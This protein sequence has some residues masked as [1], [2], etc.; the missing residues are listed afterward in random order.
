MSAQT[1]ARAWS[2][3]RS[4]GMVL[5]FTDHDRRLQFGG[6]TFRPD[7]G[8][9]ARAISQ[10]TGLAVDNSEAVGALSDDAITE[11]DLLSGRWDGASLRMWEVN[12]RDVSQRRLVFRGTLGEVSRAN[13]AFRAELRG[14][15]EPL[16][17]AQGRIYHPRCTA[18]LGDAS[19][20]LRLD[21]PTWTVEV[22]VQGLQDGRVFSMSAFPAYDANW[23]EGGTLEVL[24][25]AAMGLRGRIKNDTARP[26]QR[27]EIEL[28][29]GLAIP[30]APGDRIR[31]V[32]GCDKA[33]DT[34]RLKFS[35]LLNFRG[36]PHLP[37]EDWLL[38]PKLGGRHG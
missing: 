17:H 8:L 28:W 9:T 5:G 3:R 38:A 23:F 1:L 31:L 14:L 19:C 18:E 15:A 2:I 21:R 36:F 29:A 30:P 10:A 20:K 11:I 25:G 4:D 35:N 6:V 37:P 22:A 32:A 13:G 24:D 34:C 12:W 33:A 16:S 26:G 27:R 7:H